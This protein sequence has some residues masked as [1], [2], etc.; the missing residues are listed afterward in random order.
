M[1][2]GAGRGGFV[3]DLFAAAEGEGVGG[4]GRG[5]AV[6][7][8]LD[9]DVATVAGDVEESLRWGAVEVGVGGVGADAEDDRV[10]GR[11]FR[12]GQVGYGDHWWGEAD[13]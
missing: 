7:F 10:E 2:R 4:V 8:V 5:E 1:V 11:E 9:E 6:G 13:G 12:G 3:D